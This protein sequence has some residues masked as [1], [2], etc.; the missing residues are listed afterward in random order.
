MHIEQYT[1][2]PAKHLQNK[3]STLLWHHATPRD[4]TE[5]V[6][7]WNW[8]VLT[9]LLSLHNHCFSLTEILGSSPCGSAVKNLISIHEE[10]GS[11]SGLA[12]W[13]KDQTLW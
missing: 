6:E 4:S 8:L 2:Q 9:L 11:I 12:Q 3:H 10:M 5:W 13:V 1:R 7:T